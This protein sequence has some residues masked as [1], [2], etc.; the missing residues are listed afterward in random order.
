MS[1]YQLERE[2]DVDEL[3]SLLWES[4]SPAVRRRA[5][6]VLGRTGT[7]ESAELVRGVVR[8]A[9]TDDEPAVRAAAIDALDE[10]GPSA[11]DRLLVEMTGAEVGDEADWVT[12][13]RYVRALSA[14]PPELRMAAANALGRLGDERNVSGL[15]DALC[16]ED[17]RVRARA[18]DALGRIGDPRAVDGLVAL[19][20]DPDA[21]ARRA[22][23]DA[24][25]GVGTDRAL[26][27]LLGLLDDA[28]EPLRVIAAGALGDA[29]D[30]RPVSRLAAAL[31]DESDAV[32]RAAALSLLELLSNAPRE[33]SHAVR[34]AVV[35]ELADA[36]DEAV[37]SPLVDV[38]SEGTRRPQR[39]NAAWLLGRVAVA[40]DVAERVVDALCD[41]LA[42]EDASTAQ[43]AATSLATLGGDA[44]E[45]RLLGVVGDA[46]APPTARSKAAFVLGRI[47][48]ERSR[49][50]L[51]KV[52]DEATDEEVRRS[53][54]A[55][56]AK[57]GGPA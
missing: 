10:L 11:I 43:F 8:A 31:A 33:R 14:D 5:A 15:V 47:G 35:A 6:E 39:R 18:A 45:R 19:L 4:D 56:L 55:A 21:E 12:A 23:A 49:E 38:L 46:S 17:A 29:G 1:L 50:T 36:G 7:D 22:A 13:R 52:R 42:D 20:T 28:S 25:A 37:V 9:R 51:G 40:D 24:L 32:R 26:A 3:L 53:V 44:V 48:G 30:E 54:F 34:E 57:L 27:A 2:G 41:A 16:D